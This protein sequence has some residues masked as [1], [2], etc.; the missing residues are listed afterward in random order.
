MFVYA[1]RQ[2][3]TRNKDAAWNEST[4]YMVQENPFNSPRR[5]AFTPHDVRDAGLR[6]QRNPED[7]A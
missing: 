1:T 4:R 6:A 7:F 3:A 2:R 5:Q